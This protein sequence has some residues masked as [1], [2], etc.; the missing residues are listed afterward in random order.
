M[1]KTA[2]VSDASMQAYGSQRTASFLLKD[3]YVIRT[4]PRIEKRGRAAPKPGHEAQK[5]LFDRHIAYQ[6]SIEESGRLFAAGPLFDAKGNRVGGLIII[7]AESFDDARRVAEA[8]PH[9]AS[10][11]WE[12]DIHRWRLS[13]GSYTVTVKYSSQSADIA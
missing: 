1:A 13:E 12:Y 6:L 10:K 5:A 9:H 8:D 4:T 7:R 11:L 3:F 2:R